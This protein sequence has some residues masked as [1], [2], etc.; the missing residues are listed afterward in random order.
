ME[1]SFDLDGANSVGEREPLPRGTEMG[2]IRFSVNDGQFDTETSEMPVSEVLSRAG[3]SADHC[4]LVLDGTEYH[5][6]DQRITIRDGDHFQTKTRDRTPPASRAVHYE[7]NG[8]QQTT[9]HETL[10]LGAILKSA[11]PAASIDDSQITDYYLENVADGRKYEELS[12]PVQIR[13][14]DRFIAVHCGRTPVA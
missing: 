10:T 3:V 13:D 5:D 14:G 7:V 8:E 6:R 12:T 9:E 2:K 4:D 11:G 1:S